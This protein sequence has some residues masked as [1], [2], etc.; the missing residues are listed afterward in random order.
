[1]MGQV[2][3]IWQ[4][5]VL[6]AL[7]W[8]IVGIELALLTILAGLFAEKTKR[9][10][11]FGILALS[12][13]LGTMLGGFT[14]GP[15]VDQWGYP[16]L[17]AVLALFWCLLPLTALFLE[18]KVTGQMRQDDTS[19]AGRRTGL[20]KDFSLLFLASTA[21]CIVMFVGSMCRSLVMNERGFNAAAISGAEAIGGAVVLPLPFLMGWLSDRIGRKRL[22]VLCY[23]AGTGGLLILGGAR[24]LWQFWV[25]AFLLKS[26]VSINRT[27]GSALTTDLVPQES[28]GR[29]MS[30]FTTTNWIAGIIGFA[31]T[32]YAV[33]HLGMFSTL[34]I[35][36]LLPL[37]GIILLIPIRKAVQ[38]GAATS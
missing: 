31:G 7:V 30:L 35:G 12:N 17:F 38:E 6:T 36:A 33:Q 20:G 23:L 21:A 16:I 15:I 4:L 32:G 1:M 25:V 2:T 19:T 11:I 22:L 24:S 13:P 10:K 37:I 3:N 18:D 5:A 14:T 28:L 8:F 29:G 27:V 9:G 26:L 34:S